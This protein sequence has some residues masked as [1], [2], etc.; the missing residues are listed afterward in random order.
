MASRKRALLTVV[1]ASEGYPSSA[2]TGRSI[3][4]LDVAEA[5]QSGHGRAWVN[6]A[7]VKLDADGTP[8]SSGG[9]VLSVTG[10]SDSLQE[11]ADLAYARLSDLRW[12]APTTAVTSAHERVF[13]IPS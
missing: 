3:E 13:S 5:T 9:R 6:M 7:G 2:V 4:G 10:M 1:L 12:R 8:I 11:A